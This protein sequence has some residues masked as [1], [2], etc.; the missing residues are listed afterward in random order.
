VRQSGDHDAAVKATRSSAPMT[1]S[2]ARSTSSTVT[3][4][5]TVGSG[6][7]SATLT[8]ISPRQRPLR[9]LSTLTDHVHRMALAG[10]S[11][12]ILTSSIFTEASR[13]GILLWDRLGGSVAAR[14]GG[15]SCRSGQIVFERCHLEG[16]ASSDGAH[17]ITSTA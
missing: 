17:P 9:S 14:G 8:V 7:R 11:G 5:L 16:L 13:K 1:L 15:E 10:L 6:A 12:L 3:M 2:S 4:T